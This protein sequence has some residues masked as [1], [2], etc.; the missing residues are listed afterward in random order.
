[1]GNLIDELAKVHLDA[2]DSAMEL[3]KEMKE[4][5]T[6]DLLASPSHD[7]EKNQKVVDDLNRAGDLSELEA[8]FGRLGIDKKIESIKPHISR[9]KQIIH[10]VEPLD[11][12]DIEAMK[13]VIDF[14]ECIDE[15]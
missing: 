8:I 1:M 4:H 13:Q 10:G 12:D 14:I 5:G 7:K 2:L 15:P 6:W 3:K 11:G 9:I